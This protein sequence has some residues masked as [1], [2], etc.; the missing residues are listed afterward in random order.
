MASFA[1]KLKALFSITNGLDNKF[2][3]DITDILI[4]SDMG[5][6]IAFDITQKLESVCKKNHIEEKEDVFVKLK[7]LLQEQLLIKDLSLDINK[8]NVILV[9]G[10][11]GVGK[12]TTIAK[13]A[14]L[15]ATKYSKQKIVLAAAD[16][17][18][19]AAIEQ[20]KIHGQKL[21]LRVV[22]GQNG[23]DSASV[24]FDAISAVRSMKG[25]IVLADTAGRL[26]NKDNLLN[27]LKK[28]DKVC[29]TKA[30]ASCVY[31]LLVLDSTTGQNAFMQAEAFNEVVNI[32]YIALTKYDSNAR[33]GAVFAISQKLK[34]P[35][36]YLGTGEKIEDIKIANTS[37]FVNNFIKE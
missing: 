6:S 30:D 11:N 34:I 18:R 3:E 20:I 1:Q 2:F 26:H 32:D 29:V 7:D 19:A 15:F 36:C 8:V 17:F 10:V 37:D 5:A 27:E 12:T 4:E 16:T 31:K 23:S 14:N 9:L 24:V 13:I 35:L 21:G 33:G 28:I 25:G 22:A